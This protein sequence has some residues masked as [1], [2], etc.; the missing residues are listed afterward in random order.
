MELRGEAEKSSLVFV[1]G[2]APS[3]SEGRLFLIYSTVTCGS[4]PLL[5]CN[6]RVL[7]YAGF[8]AVAIMG[9][10]GRTFFIQTMSIRRLASGGLASRPG[11]RIEARFAPS[12]LPIAPT[13]AACLRM[14]AADPPNIDGA[15]ETAR[16]T[17]RDGDRASEVI[18]RLRAP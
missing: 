5:R 1:G 18:T 7:D 12:T 15:R 4:A 6:A 14:L 17:I 11:P 2:R 9:N 8:S 13:P 3:E 16:C 10:G